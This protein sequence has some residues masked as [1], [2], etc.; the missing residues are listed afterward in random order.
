MDAKNIGKFI[1]TLRKEKNMTQ[2]VLAEKLNVSNRTISKWENGDG[3]PDITTLP[4]IAKAL[5]VTVDELLAG[6]KSDE[7]VADIK[8]TEIKNKD[9]L[10][11][12]FLISYVIAVFVGAFGAIL[13]GIT[14]IYSI[15]AFRWLFYN[16]WEIVFV[17]VSLFTNIAS[18]LIF[19]VGVTRLGVVYTKEEIIAKSAK[20][21]WLLS[22]ILSVFPAAFT[23]RLMDIFI[24]DCFKIPNGWTPIVSIFIIFLL[25]GVFIF[26]YKKYVRPYERRM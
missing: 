10:D 20:K 5:G 13:G 25:I 26:A 2:A 21:I 8:I 24:I 16:H 17:A 9:N 6:E 22:I 3:Y 19:A 15:W 23:F 14:E 7:K 4:E 1:C 18:G 12:L 11:N